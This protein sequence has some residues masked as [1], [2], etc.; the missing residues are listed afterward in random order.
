MNSFLKQFEG[1]DIS[2]I[3]KRF[4]EL[5][6]FENL[7][8]LNG[9]EQKITSEFLKEKLIDHQRGGL[10]YELNALLFLTLKK[11][12]FDVQLATGTV[13]NEGVWAIDDTHATVLL[14]RDG[15]LC[16]VESGFGNRLPFSPL[17]L[18]GESASS[19]A[20][21]FR[22][23]TVT[24]EKGT[25]AMEQLVNDEWIVRYGF[26]PEPMEW[27][28]L[29]KMKET[30]HYHEQSTF[31]QAPVIAGIT[32]GGTFSIAR[33]RLRLKWPDGSEK[34]VT[35]ENDYDFLN[36]VTRYCSPSIVK[37][38]KLYLNAAFRDGQK[39]LK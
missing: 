38:T 5:F 15:H 2:F 29:T 1:H 21:T 3:L 19:P 16:L 37:E 22:F 18:D 30:I 23:R 12:G 10:C 33:D 8:V 20:G 6:P 14:Q 36:E 35:F 11:L 24:T 7:D 32:D 28:N 39:K 31:T 4:A 13:K 34:I 17:L 26:S 27:S 9:Y 25:L